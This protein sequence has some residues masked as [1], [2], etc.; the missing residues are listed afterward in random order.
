[1]FST[2]HN[3]RL[4]G[5]AARTIR[6]RA[7]QVG[8]ARSG[9]ISAS[10][11]FYLSHLPEYITIQPLT[12]QDRRLVVNFLQRR[13]SLGA[14]ESIGASLARRFAQNMGIADPDQ[15][16]TLSLAE[17]FLEHIARAF[18]QAERR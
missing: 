6:S 17:T 9:K 15:F 3:Q 16:T 11:P 12:E 4:G 5:L 13:F 14:R 2:R 18:E 8:S 7:P 1:M 10:L